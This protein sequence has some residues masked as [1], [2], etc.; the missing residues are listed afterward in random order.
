MF[1][2]LL[3]LPRTVLAGN[4]RFAFFSGVSSVF[5]WPFLRTTVGLSSLLRLADC[6]FN[7]KS[8]LKIIFTM[9]EPAKKG[10]VGHNSVHRAEL[11]CPSL[12]TVHL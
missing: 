7:L 4:Y 2:F 1:V 6:T 8:I 11:N 3:T 5:C 12:I 9:V 10:V